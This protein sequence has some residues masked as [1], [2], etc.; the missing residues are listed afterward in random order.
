MSLSWRAP[1]C[2]YDSGGGGDASTPVELD[3]LMHSIGSNRTRYEQ[4]LAWKRTQ[5]CEGG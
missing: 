2:R 4:Q 5:V 1:C 3:A